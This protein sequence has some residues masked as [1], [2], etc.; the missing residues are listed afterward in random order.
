MIAFLGALAGAILGSFLATIVLRWPAGRSVAAG[1][2][3][4][5]ACGTTLGARDLVPIVS[6]L[7]ARQ[8]CRTCGA[9]IDPTHV[10]IEVTCALIGA[11]ALGLAPSFLTGAALAILGWLLVPLAWLD[12]RHLWLPDRL[13][14]S[15][16]GAGLALGG[17]ASHASLPDRL[18]GGVAGFA[19]LWVLSEAYRALRAREGLG[20]G[21]AKLLGALGLW[22]GW[23]A[24][25]PVLLLS[26]LTGIGIAIARSRGAMRTYRIP[27][28]TALAASGFIAAMMMAT[29]P[30]LAFWAR[31]Q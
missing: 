5:D 18:I 19:S 6:A 12:W 31:G 2:S 9:A 1:R 22:V 14:L 8:R 13:T 10:R 24:L 4:C 26:A 15:L 28:G 3:A 11:A 25:P 30:D 29:A 23:A 21:D 20:K 16:A 7:V 17:I 27:F